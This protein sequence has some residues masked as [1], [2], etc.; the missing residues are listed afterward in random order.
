VIP[1][2]RASFML[3]TPFRL[4][5]IR[6]ILTSHF[7]NPILEHCMTVPCSMEK[8]PRH[9]YFIC[10]CEDTDTRLLPQSQ[11][12]T[13]L[14]LGELLLSSLVVR[15]Q[16]LNDDALTARRPAGLPAHNLLY[17]SHTTIMNRRSDTKDP[18]THH[19]TR[20]LKTSKL[21]ISSL[22]FSYQ[23]SLN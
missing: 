7:R 1:R 14:N 23:L 13:P 15:E 9:L 20:K 10:L 18:K 8:N 22:K 21:S 4:V 5:T 19:H 3:D 16:L 17:F 12:C 11:Q 2:P 6:Y